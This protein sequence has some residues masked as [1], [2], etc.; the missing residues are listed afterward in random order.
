MAWYFAYCNKWNSCHLS[1]LLKQSFRYMY[2]QSL[3]KIYIVIPQLSWQWALNASNNWDPRF[4]KWLG[5]KLY[6][7]YLIHK[8]GLLKH[9]RIFWP[10]FTKE[11]CR[12]P[13]FVDKPPFVSTNLLL[14]F[15]N[16]VC[17]KRVKTR[18]MT[19]INLGLSTNLLCEFGPLCLHV[20]VCRSVTDLKVDMQIHNA[21]IACI[22]IL[23]G[24]NLN[25]YVTCMIWNYCNKNRFVILSSPQNGALT[26]S[27][28]RV[29]LWCT[30]CDGG[31]MQTKSET[32]L[33]IKGKLGSQG[34]IKSMRFEER[35]RDDDGLW[36]GIGG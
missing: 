36:H 18:H 9:V 1:D 12:Q 17:K 5:P 30:D 19:Y 2:V 24:S 8:I 13:R 27:T 33:N 31:S 29:F 10:E 3:W 6:N 4:R 23:I 16:Q 25:H 26:D 32:I 14:C 21:I 7:L 34:M 28:N 35:W 20:H 15:T 11:V 22:S